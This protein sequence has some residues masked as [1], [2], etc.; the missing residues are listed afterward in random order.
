[1][2]AM[3]RK[4]AELPGLATALRTARE[5]AGLSQ[6]ELGRR[7][8]IRQSAINKIE[9]GQRRHPGAGTLAALE[10]V[11]GV[12][13]RSARESDSLKRFLASRHA[14]LLEITPAEAAELQDQ[15]W[16]S[17]GEPTDEEWYE[18]VKLRRSICARLNRSDGKP[19]DRR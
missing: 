6:S 18:Y 14:E 16:G 15:W 9:S 3:V 8:G 10:G 19:P 1:M 13:F 7:S 17:E 2:C 12:R 4:L 5:S 11:L